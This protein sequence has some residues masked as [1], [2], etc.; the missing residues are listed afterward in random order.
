[1]ARG[2]ARTVPTQ[3]RAPTV[4]Q[5]IDKV[6][7]EG[8][9]TSIKVMRDGELFTYLAT[10]DILVDLSEYRKGIHMSRLIE[11]IN[12]AI[13]LKA[14]RPK[15]SLETLG[16]E[17]LMELTRRHP[18]K[19]AEIAISTSLVLKRHTPVSKKPTYETYDVLAKVIWSEK[20]M[21]KYLET[22]VIGNTLCPHSLEVTGGKTHIQRCEL[23]LGLN[24][25]LD[26]DLLFEKL[27]DICEASFS[28]PTFTVLK[29]VD[30]AH[31]VE[32]MYANP[33]FVE[34]VSRQCLDHV[35]G[36]GIEGRVLIKAT[37][38]ESIHK[39][40]AV[41]EIRRVLKTNKEG[42]LTAF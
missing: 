16:A 8:L 14:G 30:E 33:M 19:Q 24:V 41:A 1:M 31:L 37:S 34:D 29:T 39:H 36:L 22:S 6:G 4:Q 21:R 20:K 25:E 2:Y 12:E 38:F 7:I 32:Q 23:K 17:V 3:D 9:R 26:E 42:V 18:F 35:L 27:I 11:S 28:A 13:T 40:D 10:I 15:A 5:S